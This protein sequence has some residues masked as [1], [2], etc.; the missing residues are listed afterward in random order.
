[1]KC[2]L[3]HLARQCRMTRMGRVVGEGSRL[4]TKE[5]IGEKFHEATKHRRGDTFPVPKRVPAFKVYASPLETVRLA[6]SKTRGGAGLWSVIAARRSTPPEVGS[7]ITP[8]E[9]AQLLWAS[10]GVTGQ[11]N[12]PN[13]TSLPPLRAAPSVSGAYPLETYVI[14]RNVSDTFAG[15]YHYVVREHQL[16]Q[17][18]IGDVTREL[19]SAL[20]GEPS[21]E[22]SACALVITGV[23]ERV[24]TN[25][26]ERGFRYL[27]LEA[28]H[29]AQNLLLAG[30]A[31]GL[32]VQPIV[33][34][35]DDE[36]AFLLGLAGNREIPLMTI[37]VGR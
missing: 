21:V 1:M 29:A 33:T 27:Y 2:W 9:I 36:L 13:G 10:Q 4:S 28:G 11:R 22:V 37:L 24:T 35:Y 16:E 7:S 8:T 17:V 15:V 12:Q 30:T 18:R 20:L 25:H 31:L 5:G 19:A 14:V 3:A 6:P 32:S 23:V 34:F 26:S